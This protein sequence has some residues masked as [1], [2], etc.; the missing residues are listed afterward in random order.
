MAMKKIFKKEYYM[1]Q[2]QETISQQSNFIKFAL[3]FVVLGAALFLA[4][5]FI[6]LGASTNLSA[7][8]PWGIWITVDVVI[9][10]AIGCGGFA[11]A[12]LVY[13]FNRGEYHPLVR[14]AILTSA[15]GYSLAGVAVIVDLGR[16]WN[17][18]SLV[19]PWRWN[20]HSVLLEVALCVMSYVIVLWIEFSP[21][22][23]EKG[24]S[25]G[26]MRIGFVRS[27]VGKINEKKGGANRILM[28]VVTLGLLLP[29][30]HQTSLGTVMAIAKTKLHPL[31]HTAYL[32]ILFLIS[33]V[34]LGFGI[35]VIEALYSSLYLK[36]KYETGILRRMAPIVA[37]VS[38]LWI[39]LRF[40]VLA[41]EGKT[42]YIGSS[43]SMTLF[44]AAEMVSAIIGTLIMYASRGSSS[45]KL[46]FTGALFLVFSAILYRA[47]VYMAG[48]NSGSGY[49]YIPAVT[50]TLVTFG[51]FSAE[52]ALYLFFIKSL[53]VVP[54]ENH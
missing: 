26:V 3:M 37:S 21:V 22:L 14:S 20:L 30:M 7:G 15:F 11:M 50:E 4:R 1:K 19:M 18:F 38:L 42:G 44:F 40:I 12:L 52:I 35:V 48:Y 34:S 45:P 51:L 49:S 5:F 39:V 36:R 32:P 46:M 16:W 47:D 25:V 43:G 31:W 23:H 33:V 53:P 17:F 2:L 27:I 54:A 29:I 9:G 8:Y 28:V 41:V 6:G 10:T 13:L 24:E